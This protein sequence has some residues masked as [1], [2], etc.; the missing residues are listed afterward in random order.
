[1]DQAIG[2]HI[3]LSRESVQAMLLFAANVDIRYYLCGVKVEATA[4]ATRL[5]ATNGHVMAIHHA[6]KDNKLAEPAQLIVPR[7]ALELLLY[8]SPK[9]KPKK[10][11][12]PINLAIEHG[13]SGWWLRDFEAGVRIGFDPIEGKFPDYTKAV[14]ATISGEPCNINPTYIGL[15]AKVAAAFGREGVHVGIG[16]NGQSNAAL[17]NIVGV[18]QFLGL[19]MPMRDSAPVVRPGWFE[20]AAAPKEEVAEAA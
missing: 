9:R 7:K 17:V 11:R 2:V 12:L 18:P 19:I 20:P 6:D 14:P 4:K 1:M 3:E 16:R 5:I 15:M 13:A 8:A 10:G